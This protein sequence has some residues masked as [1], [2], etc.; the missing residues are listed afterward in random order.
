[1]VLAF[2]GAHLR[3]QKQYQL[4]TYCSTFF[5]I[6]MIIF[7]LIFPTSL[8]GNL[9]LG[10]MISSMNTLCWSLPY[11]LLR[12]IH[13]KQALN[14]LQRLVS[15]D[16]IRQ[17]RGGIQRFPLSVLTGLV[18]YNIINLFL[19]IFSIHQRTWIVLPYAVVGLVL[20]SLVKPPTWRWCVFS[21]LPLCIVLNVT[22]QLLLGITDE[23]WMRV[24]A[25]L[26]NAPV[27]KN[28]LL[29]FLRAM[30]IVGQSIV[31][32]ASSL[33]LWK[34]R[35]TNQQ[36]AAV[37]ASVRQ[38][39]IGQGGG[40][41]LSGQRQSTSAMTTNIVN[42]LMFYVLSVWIADFSR[43]DPDYFCGSLFAISSAGMLCFAVLPLVNN[44]RPS[45][46]AEITVV[47]FFIHL[48]AFQVVCG[49]GRDSE[50]LYYTACAL[51]L[52]TE[53]FI[54]KYGTRASGYWILLSNLILVLATIPFQ[55]K[56]LLT[57]SAVASY[58]IFFIETYR[59]TGKNLVAYCLIVT[60]VGTA[61][62][63]L[64]VFVSPIVFL[65]FPTPL[66]WR[67]KEFELATAINDQILLLFQSQ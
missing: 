20:S 40:G 37:L 41:T 36:S 8:L 50:V 55:W 16:N 62:I 3:Q 26:G 59:L 21:D 28:F 35:K 51:V 53:W 60:L 64:V 22:S 6:E 29:S 25:Q 46:T 33:I 12:T 52:L 43:R 65:I 61:T 5:S 47:S 45:K 57:V 42:A 48:L 19:L 44:L 32:S 4:I 10:A 34:F 13:G 1:M 24:L 30:I 49:S 63:Y 15:W 23:T 66:Q 27:L 54:I 31:L 58:L 9:R 38:R 56:L 14:Q 39:E 7:A 18:I 17:P 2:A 67:P 11:I